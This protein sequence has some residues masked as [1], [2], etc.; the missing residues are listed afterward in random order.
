MESST[1]TVTELMSVIEGTKFK[2]GVMVLSGFSHLLRVLTREQ[3]LRDLISLQQS[4]PE[5]SQQV[6]ERSQKLLADNPKS[7][8]RHQHDA[9][10]TAYL[11][12][13]SQVNSP[14]T[15]QMI[16]AVRAVPGLWWANRMVQHLNAH[17]AEPRDKEVISYSD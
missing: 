6:W 8:Q 1:Q 11:Y 9:A 14:R 10:L 12:A 5:T 17:Q 7:A 15:Q 13:L 16:D 3:V 4:S 2:I